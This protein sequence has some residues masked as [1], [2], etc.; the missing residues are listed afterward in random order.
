MVAGNLASGR[1]Q[2]TTDVGRAVGASDIIFI[3]VGTPPD[4]DGSADLQHVLAVAKTIGRAMEGEKIVITKSTVPVGTAEKV[5]GAIEAET[6][7]DDSLP[8][9]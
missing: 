8:C 2:F 4:E 1:L 7:V 3:A 6:A 5:R 9:A